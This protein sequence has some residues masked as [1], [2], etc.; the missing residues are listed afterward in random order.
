MDEEEDIT[1]SE[2][3]EAAPEPVEDDADS[4][5][6]S[7][8]LTK[9]AAKEAARLASR[10]NLDSFPNALGHDERGKTTFLVKPGE[11]L[12]I[13]R[14]ATVLIG[15]PWLDTKTYTVQSIDEVSGD[16]KLWD[17]ELYR[18]AH[19]NYYKGSEAGYRFC[20]AVKGVR[21]ETH[22]KRGRPR[23]IQAAPPPATPSPTEAV[24][25]KKRGRPKGSKNKVA[26]SPTS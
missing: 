12:I 26:V 25:K 14:F 16:V 19:T 4:D 11:K 20:R 8:F 15:R 22:R 7:S 9:M 18:F 17:D 21:V 13:E 10:P 24:G 5:S 6:P 1:I 3:V 2:E 23:K